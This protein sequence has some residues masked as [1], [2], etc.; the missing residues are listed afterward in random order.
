MSFEVPAVIAKAKLGSAKL[1]YRW[2]A[3][4]KPWLTDGSRTPIVKKLSEMSVRGGLALLLAAGEW[5]RARLA[6]AG[7]PPWDD[8]LHAGWGEVIDPGSVELD[9][10]RVE[11][12]G[13][14]NV[15]GPITEY[16]REVRQVFTIARTFDG[17]F[18]SYVESGLKL[19]DHVMPSRPYR[20]WRTA[21]YPRLAELAGGQTMSAVHRTIAAT[22]AQRGVPDDQVEEEIIETQGH[23]PLWGPI[24][25]REDLFAAAPLDAAGREARIAA[26]RA[27]R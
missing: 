23:A 25:V 27:G 3:D 7:A 21:C 14:P 11:L 8:A 4:H 18:H 12:T 19:V 20:A 15:V 2:R 10:L 16:L 9:G 6:E 13:A 24:V 5:L 22:A 1:D 26:V 17:A